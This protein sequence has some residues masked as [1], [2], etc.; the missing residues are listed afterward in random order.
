MASEATRQN[1]LTTSQ[2][3]AGAKPSLESGQ[4]FDRTAFASKDSPMTSPAA[5]SSYDAVI[6]GARC[7]GAA[8]AMLLAR[9]GLRIL[10]LDRGAYGAD[11]L[12]THALMRGGVL[13]LHRWGLLDKII[14][15]GTPPVTEASFHYGD[16]VVSVRL[17]SRDGVN[18]LFAPRRTI[19]D[20]V[21]VDAAREA[22]AEVVYGTRVSA[23]T[24][25]ADGRVTGLVVKGKQGDARRIPAGIV[26]GADG[27]RSTIGALVQAP[28]YRQGHHAT[29]VVYGYWQGL[30]VVGYEWRYNPGVSTG[31]IPTNDATCVFA[32]MPDSRFRD[33][34]ARDVEAG[35]RRVIAECSPA[36]EAGLNMAVRIG[37]LHGF[38]GV[39][40]F[41]RRSWGPGWAL[42]GDAGY[43]K[44]PLTAHGITDAFRDA[45]LLAT[46]VLQCS[47]HALAEYERARDQL[48]LDQFLATD[49]IASFDWD[50]TA[51]PALHRTMS[52]EMAKEVRA[53]GSFGQQTGNRCGAASV[54]AKPL[55]QLA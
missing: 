46:A 32:A 8:T 37:T 25:D 49:A 34:I 4:S 6:V 7:A 48:A 31:I 41:F 47:I 5:Q 12:S 30:D 26:I 9:Q 22:G 50:L 18:A 3:A 53:I 1:W 2:H 10:V 20:R 16:E 19:L 44:D 17:K 13:Q 35:Y 55:R 21:L 27:L 54:S 45:E 23:L 51:L 28:I 43:F 11:T 38:P 29:G 42:V 14:E 33:E 15:A 52:D 39:P 40:G 24:T 36:L